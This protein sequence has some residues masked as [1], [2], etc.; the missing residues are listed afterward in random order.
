MISVY[1]LPWYERVLP[2]RL[3]R[4]VWRHRSWIGV[5]GGTNRF[6]VGSLT[7]GLG[8]AI[9]VIDVRWWFVG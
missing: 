9:L 1:P 5:V 4:F 2:L 6:A 3:R 7:V 8:V